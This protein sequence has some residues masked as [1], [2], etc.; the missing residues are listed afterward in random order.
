MTGFSAWPLI[1]QATLPALDR[2]Q[3][4]VV[5]DSA[6]HDHDLRYGPIVAYLNR[7]DP[8]HAWAL[9]VMKQ[10]QP[11]ALTCESVLT[12]AAYFLR[13]DRVDVDPLFQLV[14]R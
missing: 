4:T 9:A 5:A 8:Y 2:R 14:E 7:N 6:K 11:P 10:V 12:E 13:E 3:R 1:S